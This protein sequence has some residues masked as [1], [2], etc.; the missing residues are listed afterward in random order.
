MNGVFDNWR[1]FGVIISTRNVDIFGFDFETDVFFAVIFDDFEF[2]SVSAKVV[3]VGEDWF[4]GY[5]SFNVSTPTMKKV[6]KY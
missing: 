2:K 6:E 3:I 4:Q 5:Y 1:E